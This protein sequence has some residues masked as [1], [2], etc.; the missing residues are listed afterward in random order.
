MSETRVEITCQF[1]ATYRDDGVITGWTV[2]PWASFAGFF[3]KP[4]EVLEGDEDLDV[5][6]TD[7]PF[8][9]AVQAHLAERAQGASANGVPH[10]TVTWEE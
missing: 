5:S 7:G 10:L 1:V 3:G 9:K 6:D 8:W 4:A 2:S